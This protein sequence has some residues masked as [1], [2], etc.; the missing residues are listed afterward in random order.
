MIRQLVAVAGLVA[1]GGLTA[2][3]GNAQVTLR[4]TASFGATSYT[5]G[6]STSSGGPYTAIATGV[7][8]IS[9]T[10]TGLTNGTT[11][12][13]VVSAVNAAGQSPNSSQVSATPS[14]PVGDDRRA[15][16]D[17]DRGWD[18]HRHVCGQ[19]DGKHG[20]GPDRELHRRRLR[21]S[22]QRLHR[23]DEKRHHPD[24]RCLGGDY[25]DADQ[26]HGDR[27]RRDSCGFSDSGGAYLVGTPS[28]ATVSIVSDDAAP[29]AGLVAAFGFDEGA[30]TT[31]ARLVR[32]RQHGCRCPG[33][34]GS[35]AGLGKALSFDGINDLV[36]V[37]DSNSLDLTGAMTLEAWVRPDDAE[38]VADTRPEG[39][40]G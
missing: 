33:L 36:T 38:R 19:Q 32:T 18:D 3:P 2:T 37:N 30:G 31:V 28:N 9:H 6:R 8:G 39:T 14:F 26:R 12:Y 23:A 4:W 27:A 20:R 13:Y 17:G 29:S 7:T 5:V 35:M 34:H 16:S 24:W 25:G 40:A 22:R 15:G 21:D 1:P 11:Y 10:D